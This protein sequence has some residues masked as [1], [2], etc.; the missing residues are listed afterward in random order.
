MWGVGRVSSVNI[1]RT[2]REFGAT[3]MTRLSVVVPCYNE[4]ES[5]P[6]LWRRV[7][8]VSKQVV[9]DDY[10]IVLV[11]D[12]S[13]DR[14]WPLIQQF[15][16]KDGHVVCVRLSRNH[17]HQLALSAGLMVCSG[18]RIL[19]IDADLQDPPELLPDM[20]DMIDSGADVVY[21]QRATRSGET[22]FKRVTARIFYRVLDHMVEVSIPLDTGD[23]RL[24][25]RRV[26]DALNAMPEHYRFVR[27]MVSWLG[28]RQEPLI[29]DRQERFAGVTK[30]PLSKMVR[31]GI[32]AITSFSI[33]PLRI[34]S[35]LGA[36]FGVLGIAGL[37]Y[38]LVSWLQGSVVPGW[39][40]VIVTVLIMGSVQLFVIGV[41]GEYLGRLYIESKQRPL[42]IIDQIVRNKARVCDDPDI[43]D[44]VTATSDVVCTR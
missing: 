6:E 12:G 34:A 35:A 3:V 19:V 24:M 20:M 25:T 1:P 22:W 9:G 17:G 28:F 29:Y 32:D 15:A 36:I 38:S 39:T 43:L 5:I 4:Q 2:Q 44:Q 13:R 41:F 11:D 14:T 23:F 16:E 37:F 42:F 10:E 30:Y 8:Q 18:E 31:F 26:L 27:G 21:G 33:K 40:S 7:T